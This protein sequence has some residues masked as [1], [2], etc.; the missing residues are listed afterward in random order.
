MDPR[1]LEAR[2]REDRAAGRLP[3]LLVASAG[4]VSTGAVDPL[5]RLSEIARREGLWLHVDGAYGGFA[6][7]IEGVPADLAGLALADSVA[8]DPHKWLYAPLEAG[9]ALVRDA[10]AST[11]LRTFRRRRPKRTRSTTTPSGCRTPA[12]CALSRSGWGSAW[13]AAKAVAA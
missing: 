3:F 5:P 13:R 1:D 7:G 6:A 2:V 11:G 8:I 12:A 4:T 9:C 10:K